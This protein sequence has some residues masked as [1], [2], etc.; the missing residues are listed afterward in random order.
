MKYEDFIDLSYKPS[1]DDLIALFRIEP[2]KGYSIYDASGRV[3]SESS[4]GTW[5]EIRVNK[6]IEEISAKVFRIEGKWVYI[7]YPIDL[8]EESNMSQILSSIAGNVFGMKAL[9]NLRLEDVSWP[10][11]IKK[12]FKGASR[13]IDGVRKVLK[14]FNRPLTATVPKPK[15]GLNT[16]EFIDTATKIWRGGIDLVKDDENLTNQSFNKFSNRIRKMYRIR[17]KIEKE[18][19]DKKGYLVNIT[20]PYNEM[21]RRG[22]EVMREGGRFVMIDV[23]TAGFSAVQSFIDEFREYGVAVHAH[24]AF[25]AAFTRNPRHGMSMKVLVEIFRL[26]GVDHIHVGTVVGKLHGSYREVH[27]LVKICRES[28]IRENK[29]D[30]I[31]ENDWREFKP[32]FPVSSG[33]LHP[34]LL[35]YIVNKFG[36]ELIIQVGGGVIGHPMGIEAGARAVKAV[37]EG[38]LDG[39]TLEDIS[40]KYETVKAALDKWGF[41]TPI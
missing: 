41:K 12:S 34:G 4:V 1:K 40:N 28:F 13:G 10:Y 16:E 27:N 23:L 17:D 31:L 14:I 39:Y 18:T 22:R 19:G 8:F 3:A 21:V 2:K 26:L 5:A 35:P 9:K 38:I 30:K 15:V 25:H 36:K 7:A 29:R 20:A 37:L 24:R 11:K 6:F 33:G 32:I